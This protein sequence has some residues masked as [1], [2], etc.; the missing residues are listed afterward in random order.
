[1]L[2]PDAWKTVI[3]MELIPL[4]FF[5]NV[6][7]CCGFGAELSTC[8]DFWMSLPSS[9]HTWYIDNTLILV[10]CIARASSKSS[11]RSRTTLVLDT[12]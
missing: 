2:G 9:F 6:G 3:A 4:S 5:A 12:G 7:Q 11:S 10:E 1:M 8:D